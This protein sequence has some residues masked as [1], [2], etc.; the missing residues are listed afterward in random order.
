LIDRVAGMRKPEHGEHFALEAK[1]LC[2]Q[3]YVEE[4]WMSTKAAPDRQRP[5]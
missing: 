5:R 1:F 2:I 3:I 4:W